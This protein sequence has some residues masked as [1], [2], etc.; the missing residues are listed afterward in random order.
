LLLEIKMSKRDYYDILGV[1]KGSSAD[2]IK[3]AYRKLAI[4]YHPDKNPGDKE[5]EEKFKEAAEAYEVLSNPEKKQRYDQFGHA[6]TSGAG[7]YGG[8]SM[9]MD[10]IFSQF[11]DIFGQG[12]PFESFFGGGSRGGQRVQKGTNLR[13]KVKLSLE[14]IAN[15]VEKKIKV[16]KLKEC[17]TC[18]GT[19]AK[20][21]S[22]M[23]TCKTCNG[24]GSVRRVTNTILGQMQTTTTCPTCS[25]SGTVITERCLSCHGDG[26]NKGE[27]TISI[28]IPAGV[29]EG[30][31]LTVGGKGNAAPRGGIPGD[32]LILIEEIPHEELIRDGNNL[33][34]ELYLNFID[35]ALG[36]SVEIPT[37]DAKAKIKIEPGTQSG[38]VLRLKGKGLPEVNG[39]SRGDQLVHINIWTPKD[40]TRDERSMLEKLRESEN[41]RPNPGKNDKGFFER[42]KEMFN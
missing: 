31:Q 4:K 8:G 37:I 18:H 39:Y 6:G 35:A 34:Y 25:G 22:S 42:V 5:A 13:I 40:L 7:G 38:K 30:M 23:G 2:E 17:D 21:K 12:N 26:V 36:T 15:G 20:S 29:A 10:D 1:S 28:Q 32:L 16:A 19:G 33:L 11:G 3:K 14:E 27:E 24:M 41:F 9:N